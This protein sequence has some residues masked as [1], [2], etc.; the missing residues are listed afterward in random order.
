M[1]KEPMQ[2]WVALGLGLTVA[3]A[4]QAWTPGWSLYLDRTTTFDYEEPGAMEEEGD[5]LGGVLAY[6]VDALG[7][8]MRIEGQLGTGEM[9]YDGQTQGG[10]PATSETE[11][12]VYGLRILLGAGTDPWLFYTGLGGRSW[13]QDLKDGETSSGG[14]MIGYDRGHRYRYIPL[15]VRLERSIGA[16]WS[17]HVEAEY[18][19]VWDGEAY[20]DFDSGSMDFNMDDGHGWALTAGVRRD[21]SGEVDFSVDGYLRRWDFGT[22]D[23]DTISVNGT[24]YLFEEPANETEEVG[25]RVGVHW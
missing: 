18:R 15:G 12:Q 14:T 17:G 5:R 10:T 20:A 24:T 1:S 7:G 22:S 2:R 25:F 21:L 19:S 11:D 13:D 16:E 4:A 3:S 23:P 8:Q 6:T 9:N